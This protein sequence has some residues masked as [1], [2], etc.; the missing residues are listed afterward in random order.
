M[1]HVCLTH[2]LVSVT[3]F[4]SC[5]CVC[6]CVC[7]W[8]CVYQ[9]T[10]VC[11]LSQIITRPSAAN[12]NFP[13]HVRT[14]QIGIMSSPG[15]AF[16]HHAYGN[17]SFIGDSV[18]NFTELFSINTAAPPLATAEKLEE[19]VAQ[20]GQSSCRDGKVI[21]TT[22]AELSSVLPPPPLPPLLSPMTPP[23]PQRHGA[24]FTEYFSMQGGGTG[25]VPLD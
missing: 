2:F 22:T 9:R 18:P 16:P 21:T 14:S 3:C 17:V 8:Q 25:R 24:P 7:V 5:Q 11:L 12:K 13:Y 20:K 15:E 10:A 4:L 23:A 19:T 1:F 6:V